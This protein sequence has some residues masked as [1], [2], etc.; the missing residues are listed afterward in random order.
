MKTILAVV[1]F[2]AVC[3]ACATARAELR[4]IKAEDL[5]PANC[6]VITNIDDF[7]ELIRK[8]KVDTVFY[9]EDFFIASIGSILYSHKSQ[10]YTSFREYREGRLKAPVPWAVFKPGNSD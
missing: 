1:L 5:Y 6:I 7:E 3:S 2:A 8:N 10:G 4:F 9:T